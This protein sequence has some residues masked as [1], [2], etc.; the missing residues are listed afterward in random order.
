MPFSMNL[1]LSSTTHFPTVL[2][3]KKNQF[4]VNTAVLCEC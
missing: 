3:K 1:Y 4:A 2:K